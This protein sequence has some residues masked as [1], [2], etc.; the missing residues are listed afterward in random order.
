M[1]IQ[2]DRCKKIYDSKFD[3][4]I[5][6]LNWG[7]G[8]DNNYHLCPECSKETRDWVKNWVEKRYAKNKD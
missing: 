5:E 4:K 3:T 8:E 1:K 7:V 2:C 6:Y